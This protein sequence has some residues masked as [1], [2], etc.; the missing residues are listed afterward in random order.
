[1]P[2]Q[3]TNTEK[4]SVVVASASLAAAALALG[5][6]MTLAPTY[7]DFI[8]GSITWS[9]NTKFQDLFAPLFFMAVLLRWRGL[10]VGADQDVEEPH[11][12]SFACG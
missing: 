9:A 11:H 3:L 1:M 5:L 8:V 4:T 2:N 6:R 12:A 7:A 10:S